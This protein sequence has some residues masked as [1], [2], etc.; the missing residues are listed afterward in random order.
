[1]E[2]LSKKNQNDTIGMADRVECEVIRSAGT[3]GGSQ[4]EHTPK[5]PELKKENSD[6]QN[7]YSQE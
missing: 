2:K 6:E 1:M 7:T 3:T 4:K 5:E